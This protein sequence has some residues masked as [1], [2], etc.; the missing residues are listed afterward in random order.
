MF[1]RSICGCLA[2]IVV[3]CESFVTKDAKPTVNLNLVTASQFNHRG[4]VQNEEWVL[5]PDIGAR[6]TPIRAYPTDEGGTFRVQSK[7]YLNLTEDTGD[8]WFP[9]G[10][11]GKFS[12]IDLK[13]D[14]SRRFEVMSWP[15]DMAAGVLSYVIPNGS[16]FP[17]GPRGST[18][19]IFGN[20]GSP[21]F[22][23]EPYRFYPHFAVNYDPDEADGFYFNA[24]IGKGT[25]ISEILDI[26]GL[27]PSGGF[28][29]KVVDSLSFQI[30]VGVGYSSARESFWNYGLS[31]E[32]FADFTG[33]GTLSCKIDKNTVVSVGVGGSSIIDQDL[34]DCFDTINIENDNVWVIF[35][36][37]WEFGGASS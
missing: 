37:G 1:S 33:T 13:A 12:E 15:I 6:L 7:G 21:I 34:R 4:M 23:E 24:G 29:A 2:V 19:E 5:V 17:N 35:G 8:A 31:E 18:T 25:L 30:D 22:S 11:G 14:Y 10:Q 3:G 32:G 20:L 16:F 27:K 36:I 26:F 28:A 9:D